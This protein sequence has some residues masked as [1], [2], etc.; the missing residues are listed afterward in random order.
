VEKI[1]LGG[2]VR[3]DIIV[4]IEKTLK[5]LKLV[6]EVSKAERV[7]LAL[8]GVA[9]HNVNKS[10]W[11]AK[12]AENEMRKL[13]F[14]L[15]RQAPGVSSTWVWSNTLKEL[16]KIPHVPNKARPFGPST[17]DF[18]SRSLDSKVT[19]AVFWLGLLTCSRVGNLDGLHILGVD[20]LG[21]RLE[22]REHKT[23]THIGARSLYLRYWSPMMKAAILGNLP[24]GDVSKEVKEEIVKFFAKNKLKQHSVRRTGV[25]V[26]LG[27]RVP[28]NRVMAITLHTDPAM[29]L[30]YTD[31]YEPVIDITEATGMAASLA[32][33]I[34]DIQRRNLMASC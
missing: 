7:A 16:A 18:I 3:M 31:L 4:D 1:A 14:Y 15:E 19:R 13:K 6:G 17:I 33:I 2:P 20:E 5:N 24:L 30:S 34:V 11:L 32:P 27:A 29:L 23:Y 10:K 22:N 9:I 25:Q 12:T 26:Y 8:S 21:V 28:E